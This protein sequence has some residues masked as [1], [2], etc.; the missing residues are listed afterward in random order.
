MLPALSQRVPDA[1]GHPLFEPYLYFCV[2]LHRQRIFGLGILACGSCLELT[3]DTVQQLLRSSACNGV[4][5]AR[6]RLLCL[7]AAD[8]TQ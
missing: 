8:R 1:R 4:A 7:F 5:D 6:D 2:P 3:I